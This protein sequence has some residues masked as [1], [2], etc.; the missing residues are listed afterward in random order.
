VTRTGKNLFN[1]SLAKWKNNVLI[2]SSGVEVSN[3]GYKTTG[4]YSQI[5]P[6]SYAFQYN[7]GDTVSAPAIIAYYDKN[8]TF[9]SRT[10]AV[11]VVSGS[12]IKTGLVTVPDNTCFYRLSLL[13]NYST[14]VQVE[15]GSTATAYEPYQGNTYDITF[16]SSAG[17]V[18]GGTLD[19]VNK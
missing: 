7:K 19:V 15:L 2:N 10:Y 16:P 13:K 6:G 14:N 5:A 8:K 12:G 17:T 3:A 1:E 11:D 4:Y 18:Y 9:I